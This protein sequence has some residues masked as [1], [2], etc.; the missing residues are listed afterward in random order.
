M[1]NICE[2]AFAVY[3]RRALKARK[4]S[5]TNIS[6]FLRQARRHSTCQAGYTFVHSNATL[7]GMAIKD[8]EMR[9]RIERDLHE[10]L[11]AGS[12]VSSAAVKAKRDIILS[13]VGTQQ[14]SQGYKLSNPE[15]N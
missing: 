10:V 3:P 6:A 5:R 12:T 15:R 9:I 13:F 1:K 2:K 7:R 8:V 14:A 4:E 11:R